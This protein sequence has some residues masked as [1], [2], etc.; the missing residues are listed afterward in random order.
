MKQIFLAFPFIRFLAFGRI[1]I[2]T[3]TRRIKGADTPRYE[4]YKNERRYAEIGNWLPTKVHMGANER[5]VGTCTY[6]QAHA[7]ALHGDV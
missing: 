2:E 3:R 7:S 4:N 5:C 6:M 1:Y